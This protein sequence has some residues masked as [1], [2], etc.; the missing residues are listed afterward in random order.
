MRNDGW[1]HGTYI[2]SRQ[3]ALGLSRSAL[4]RETRVTVAMFNRLESGQRRCR[5]PLLRQIAAA[6]QVPASKLLVQAGYTSEARYRR[7]QEAALP[8][9]DRLERFEH[10]LGALHLHPTVR[11]LLV[12]LVGELIRDREEEFSQRL[13]AAVARYPGRVDADTA[14]SSALRTLPFAVEDDALG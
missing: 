13:E 11:H 5:P 4:A 6:L 2:R 8:A 14:R 7:R 1:P 12:T 9:H 10:M 3:A